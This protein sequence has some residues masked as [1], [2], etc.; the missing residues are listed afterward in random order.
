MK[1]RK[2]VTPRAI[3]GVR[4]LATA[5]QNAQACVFVRR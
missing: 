2:Y 1:R 3:F 4:W 5:F